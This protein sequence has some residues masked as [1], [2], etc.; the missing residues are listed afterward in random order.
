MIL[1][2]LIYSLIYYDFFRQSLK[3]STRG[4][5]RIFVEE[6]RKVDLDYLNVLNFIEISYD[7][8]PSLL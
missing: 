2:I 1:N 4:H 6:S 3:S 8:T 5:S 7:D